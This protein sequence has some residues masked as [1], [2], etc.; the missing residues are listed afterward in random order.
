MVCAL[1]AF[2]SLPLKFT[3]HTLC[4]HIHVCPPPSSIHNIRQYVLLEVGVCADLHVVYDRGPEQ[5]MHS[6]DVTCSYVRS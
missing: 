5:Y 2:L 3:V 1:H 6:D 4:V